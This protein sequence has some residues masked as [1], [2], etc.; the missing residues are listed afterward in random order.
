MGIFDWLK[1]P[2]TTVDLLD[3]V[4]WLTKQAK[5]TG[6]SASIG[7]CLAE[8]ARPFAVLLVAHFRDC[9]EQLQAIVQ[10]GGFENVIATT[11][12][13]L[14]GRS[15]SRLGSDDSQTVVII[16][17]ERHPLQA[18]DAAVTESAQSLPCRC[19]LVHHVS[20]E[21]PMM[22]MFAGEWVQNVLQR[23]GMNEHEAIESRMV[24]RRIQAA[25]QKIENQAVS[26]MAADSAEEWLERNCPDLW[27]TMQR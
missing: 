19:R 12:E 13:N 15:A 24:T 16:V 3:D 11:A 8:P 7:R 26:D 6:I 10:Q 23:L 21:D 20:L 27:R 18:H 25:A 2:K 4:I 14:T 1:T 5:F 22:Q 17:A 9:L